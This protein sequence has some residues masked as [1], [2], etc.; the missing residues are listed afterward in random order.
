MVKVKYIV[1]EG[2][3]GAGKSTLINQLKLRMQRKAYPTYTTFEPTSSPI[4]SMIR[5][6]LGG[7]LEMSEQTIAALFVADRLDHLQNSVNG[8]LTKINSG[9]HVLGDRYY[10]S[11]YAYH[12]PHVS[13]DWVIEANSVCAHILRP[14]ITFFIDISIDESLH[15]IAKN[16]QETDLYETRERITKTMKNYLDAIERVKDVENIVVIDGEQA[17]EQVMEEVWSHMEPLLDQKI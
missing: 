14:D 1:F 11:S 12:V 9:V 2:I 6:I 17:P 4:G 16:R 3:D 13:L 15:R 8:I 10:L 7:R 5:N